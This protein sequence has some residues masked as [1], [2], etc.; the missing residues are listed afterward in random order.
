M[1]DKIVDS[2]CH[3]DFDDFNDDLSEVINNARQNNVEYMLSISVDF[4]K[5]D[6]IHKIAKNYKNIWCST[7]VH[8][9]N[10]PKKINLK[11]IENLKNILQE[12]LS[13]EKVIGVGETGLDFYR[14]AENKKN[15]MEYFEAHMQIAGKTNTPIIIHTRNAEED[16]ISHIEKYTKKYMTKGLIHCFTST[17]EVAKSAL[18]NDLY[19]SFSGIITFKNSSE[20]TDIV[21]YVPNEKILVETDCP[22]L[23][24][25]PNRGKR[26]E[27]SFVRHTLEKIAEIK[28]I[29]PK[30]M[31]KITTNNFF[32]LFSNI[33]NEL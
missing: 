32:S 31:A 4:E 17:K 28:K 16:T 30:E 3:L 18:D 6:N 33:C 29:N 22:Y 2:H 7:G 25:S 1:K 15:Q 20:L 21:K 26:N 8:P 10:V 24:P 9:N 11:A 23:S 12:N 27:P 14:N 19:I 13:K 5:F